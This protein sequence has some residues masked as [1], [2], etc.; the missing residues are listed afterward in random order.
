MNLTFEWDT[1]KAEAN[2]K[3]HKVYFEEAKSVYNDPFL[4]TFPDP[5]HS[6]KEQRY[7]N[8]GYSSKCRILVVVHTEREGDI[9][10]ISCRK[11]TG[12]ER[13]FYEQ[14]NF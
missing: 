7:L 13:R 12:N 9:R 11:A 8:I 4:R 6:D 10:I 2:F 3:K 5:E 14:K 1:E